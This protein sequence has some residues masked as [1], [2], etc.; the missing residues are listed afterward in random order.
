MSERKKSKGFKTSTQTSRKDLV[1][2]SSEKHV[3][4]VMK[5]EK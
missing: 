2:C 3:A 1:D 5:N 4:L